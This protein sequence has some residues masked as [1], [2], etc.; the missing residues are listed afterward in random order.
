MV[1]KRAALFSCGI[2]LALVLGV[3]PGARA[4]PIIDFGMHAPTA[5]TISYA[6]LGGPLTGS[7]IQVDNVV[8]G[9]GTPE[10]ATPANNG[11]VATCVSC[12]LSYTTGDF[13]SA[14]GTQWTFAA[15]GTITLTGGIDFPDAT[16]DI[17][18]G[19]A[20]LSGSWSSPVIVSDLGSINAKLQGGVFTDIQN[21]SLAS[22]YGLV[23]GPGTTWSG[24]F[25][26]SFFAVGFAPGTFTSSA[27]ASGDITNTPQPVAVAEPGTLILLGA[28]LL[29]VG[30]WSRRRQQK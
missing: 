27:L 9:L 14:T 29:G 3:A 24:A 22:F 11:V 18:T 1:M 25:N 28:A 23:G 15:G 30:A 20:L 5:G 7:G 16:P 8:G 6:T 2:T 4:G 10:T 12:T 17:P 21:A 26:L 19:T 13:E